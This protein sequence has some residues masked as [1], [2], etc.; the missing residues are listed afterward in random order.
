MASVV[1]NDEYLSDIADAIR[2]KTGT[3]DTYKPS[4]MADAISSISGGIT[5]TGTIQITQ[6]GTVDVSQYASANVNVP[7]SEDDPNHLEMGETLFLAC[8]STGVIGGNP[9]HQLTGS[10]AP[11]ARRAL[12]STNG[13]VPVYC[14]YATNT[15]TIGGY[16][17]IEI[18]TGVTS[19]TLNID[20]SCQYT[21][22]EYL[23]ENGSLSQNGSS[24]AWIDITANTDVVIPLKQLVSNATHMSLCFRV[25]SSNTAYSASNM[26]QSISIDFS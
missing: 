6:N 25:D 1:V 24:S 12:Y 8:G 14:T 21:L 9:V 5:P 22:Q 23:I 20:K 3:Q 13:T 19:A 10:T 26:P 11:I 4:Q 16:Y 18:P 7:T 17:L 2:A 15:H